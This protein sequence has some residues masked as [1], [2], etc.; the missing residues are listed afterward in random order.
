MVNYIISIT[1]ERQL[2]LCFPPQNIII[3]NQHNCIIYRGNLQT[4]FTR[5]GTSQV[6]HGKE[7]ACQCRRHKRIRFDP[8]EWEIAAHSSILA[9]KIPWTEETGGLHQSFQWIFRTDFLSDWL[10][11][12][13]CSPRDS[14]ES[15]PTPQFKSISSLALPYSSNGKESACDAGDQG[16][17]P[18]SGRSSGERKYNPLQYSCLENSMEREAWWA[19]VHGVTKSQTRLSAHV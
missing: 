3:K 13:P 12:S 1:A 18:G 6:A 14:Q 5:T 9:W 11:W 16:S 15:S 8:L 2:A 7:S 19:I 10:V 17:I 4:A